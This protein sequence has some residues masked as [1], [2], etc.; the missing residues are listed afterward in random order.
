M[1]MLQ[2]MLLILQKVDPKSLVWLIKQLD[3]IPN[4]AIRK[5]VEDEL[6]NKNWDYIHKM[7]LIQ[8]SIYGVDIQPI[9]VELSKLRFFLTL[10]VDED[11]NDKAENRGINPLPNL[12]FKFV[13]ANTLIGLPKQEQQ[14][15]AF[16]KEFIEPKIAKLQK[17][18]EN[19][20]HSQGNEKEILKNE[21]MK[22]QE[23]IGI[24]I[25]QNK[26]IY[27]DKIANELTNWNPFKD[28][29]SDW[30]DPKWMFGVEGGFDIVIGNPPYG[31]KISPRQK[32]YFKNNYY[33]CQTVQNVRKGN[34][35]TYIAFIELG[36]KSV[37]EN[38]TLTYI[39][40]LSV[41]S[42]E[43]NI[44]LHQ[45]IEQNCSA[46]F[47]TNFSVRPRPIFLNAV[48]NTSII[49][50]VKGKSSNVPIYSTK[51]YRKKEDNTV[52]KIIKNINYQEVSRY[53][54]EGRYPK[55]SDD[56][57]K[58]ILTKIRNIKT[59]I[60][61]LIAENGSKIYY[62]FAGGRYFKVITNY[63]TNS[64]AETSL[65]LD[66]RYANS[67]GAI[68]SSNLFFWYYQIYSDNLNMKSI[69]VE[70]FPFPKNKF[71]E[72]DLKKLEEI[73]QRYLNDI[74]RNANVRTTSRYANI[75]HFKEY[76]I[77][78]SKKIIDE[79][80]NLIYSFYGLTKEEIEFIIN[81][82]ISF[83]ISDRFNGL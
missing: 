32:Q 81:Y 39:V 73:Y 46:A 62:R 80:D 28:D 4:Q 66:K 23:D 44:S 57:E 59:K 14:Q 27:S 40:P 79:I 13:A 67:I 1:G 55:I 42:S 69:E 76:K 35:D 16:D 2:K 36:L 78:K 75:S 9:A 45:Y 65:S 5:S 77:S 6:M 71:N 12:S 33:S 31:A 58:N 48:V 18:R 17:V 61:N 64:S 21:F 72:N 54:L 22:V 20:F 30:F 56:I 82:E 11:I 83:R 7:G 37:N 10:M 25:S 63:P 29:A 15:N 49:K 24:T 47:F 50:L 41:T 52:E 68:L 70:S 53:Y 34:P 43:S 38:G 74:E 3:K 8:H 26:D 51:M 19:F 60:S